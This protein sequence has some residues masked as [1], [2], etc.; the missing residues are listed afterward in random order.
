MLCYRGA[1]SKSWSILSISARDVDC[2]R[3]ATPALV[4][5]AAIPLSAIVDIR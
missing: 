4:S 5:L 3:A 1:F 2:G